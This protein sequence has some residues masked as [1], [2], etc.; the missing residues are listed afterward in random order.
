MKGDWQ[1]RFMKWMWAVMLE[2]RIFLE[3]GEVLEK[4]QV[5]STR[6]RRAC[7]KILMTVAE[8]KGVCKD[9]GKWKEV[10]SAY[11]KRK[12]GVMLCMCVRQALLVNCISVCFV[13]LAG[14]G[15]E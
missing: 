12:T 15:C 3:I 5:K 9:R 14:A 13:R 4:D 6:N 7:M 1:K 11:P 10:I 8:A 2:G